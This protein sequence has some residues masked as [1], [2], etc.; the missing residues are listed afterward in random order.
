M[1][2][3]LVPRDPHLADGKKY[4]EKWEETFLDMGSIPSS[5]KPGIHFFF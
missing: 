2:K 3:A 4:D 1:V 5:I